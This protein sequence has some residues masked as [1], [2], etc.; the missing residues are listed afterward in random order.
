MP[1]YGELLFDKELFMNSKT[2]RILCVI[3][4]AVILS[5][6]FSSVS[7]NAEDKIPTHTI[8][9]YGVGSDLEGDSG[10][11]TYNL[12]QIMR[13][14]YNENADIIVMTGGAKKWH[15]PSE[16]LSGADVISTEYN[17][18]WRVRGKGDGESHGMMTLLREKGLDG[19]EDALMSD[20]D[21]LTG[22]MDYCYENYPAD[23]YDVIMWD[24]GGG[25]VRGFGA[26]ERGGI[27]SISDMYDAF[28]ACRL[29]KDGKRFEILDFDACL[30]CTAEVIAALGGFADYFVGSAET[31]PSAG[32]EYFSWL[33]SLR[34]EPYADGAKLASYIVESTLLYYNHNDSEYAQDVTL[35][36][37]DTKKFREQV[38]P[39]LL[40]I[41]DIL[42][43]EAKTKSDKN[44]RYN[45]YDELYSLYGAYDYDYGD[46]S[47]YDLYDLLCALSVTQ[48]EFTNADDEQIST[49]S[50]AYTDAAMA[51]VNT[52]SDKDVVFAETTK[53]LKKA[54][55][56]DC[57]RSA[58]GELIWPEVDTVDVYP[59][60]ISIYFG[61]HYI[62]ETNR[63]V[64]EAAKLINRLPDGDAKEFIKKNSASAALYTLISFFGYRL[65]MI[66]DDSEPYDYGAIREYL[67]GIFSEDVFLTLFSALVDAGE[68]ESVADAETYL[69]E[70]FDQQKNEGIKKENV[71]VKQVRSDGEPT[72]QYQVTVSNTSLQAMR[73]VYSSV[74]AESRIIDSED[75]RDMLTLT[76]GEP[77]TGDINDMFM[78]GI[79]VNVLSDRGTV[80]IAE[81]FDEYTDS[82]PTVK[83]RIYSSDTSVRILNDSN[84]KV[85]VMYDADNNAH[86]C[87]VYYSDGAKQKAT[88]PVIIY[89]ELFEETFAAFLIISDKSDGWSIDGLAFSD[90]EIVERTYMPLDD[91]MFFGAVCA[92]CTLTT[93]YENYITTFIPLCEFIPV[94]CERGDW[95]I[96][97]GYEMLSD[98]PDVK[99]YK[100][101]YY[102]EDVYGSRIYITDLVRQADTAAE[103]GDYVIW[104]NNADVTI[105]DAVYN[106]RRQ[107]P[108]VTAIA[109]GKTLVE[110]K[111]Y[112]IFYDERVEPDLYSALLMGT[113]DCYGFVYGSYNVTPYEYE[114][115]PMED[116]GAAADIV[117]DENAIYGYRPSEDGSLK[118][119]AGAD[120]TD[121]DV[122]EAGRRE[123]IAYHESIAS[124]YEMLKEMKAAGKSTEEIARAVSA[125]RN[126]IRLD[127]YRDKPEE[128]EQLKQR[129]LEKYGHEEGPLPDELY[130]KYG[131]WVTVAEKAFSPNRGMDAC[132][133]LYD[134]YYDA[135]RSLEELS[136]DP[137]VSPPTA[138]A[139]IAPCV[140]IMT[141]ALAV[142]LILIKKKAKA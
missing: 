13:S 58:S 95:G 114:H 28:S 3:L 137:A 76:Y 5:C 55:Y 104:I 46:W 36:A 135:Y 109:D 84:S 50:N 25:P 126:R 140:I 81:Y 136:D 82:D 8:M 75:F 79:N 138:D 102:I 19:L 120:W 11:L 42:I 90:D 124:M 10:C 87:D 128:L 110:G 113:G 49:L 130:K 105:D 14:V 115:D 47:L 112:K 22:F 4:S 74:T 56:I 34:L 43:S 77:V 106:G 31:E 39:G 20:K 54:K 88:V 65:G 123:R 63:Y 118:M 78:Y 93:D 98:V 139:Y 134:E 64:K 35:A 57:T 44:G 17:Q 108:G 29:I 59:G 92:P 141:L 26:D 131:S 101:E 100:N 41:E 32:Q 127:A 45:F 12:Y 121:P 16:F 117:A 7:V 30:M 53:N 2:K 33:T 91:E 96:S 129:N 38:L 111:D 67:N 85:L 83:R 86:L 52:L 107:R 27:L 68:F 60:C 97:F 62:Y 23:R 122:V 94:D 72:G 142:S 69:S 73:N 99:T 70:I 15:M 125:E 116:K 119:Y 18:I 89:S 71:T 132:L 1:G 37:V 66:A 9:L 61:T 6:G 103:N 133:G 40:T 51:L 24:H 80:K 21:T 48:T